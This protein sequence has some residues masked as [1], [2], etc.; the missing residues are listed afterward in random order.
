[1]QTIGELFTLSNL[2]FCVF[3]WIMVWIQ[4]KIV[5]LTWKTAKDNKYW[6]ALFLPLGPIGTGAILAAI[7]HT[8]P[9]P[10]M[11]SQFSSKVIFGSV[12][13]LFSA[14]IYK[15]IKELFDNKFREL[16]KEKI[17]NISKTDEPE[18][19]DDLL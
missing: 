12:L 7:F 6:R 14:H 1:M 19:E 5:E 11:F 16:L 10:E 15:I 3:I 8:Y 17:K 9:F 13:G 18:S 4:R 2:V